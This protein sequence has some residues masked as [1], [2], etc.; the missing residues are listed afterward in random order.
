MLGNIGWWTFEAETHALINRFSGQRVR[1]EGALEVDAGSALHSRGHGPVRLRFCYEDA[2]VRYPVLVT[3]RYET[4][5]G[6]GFDHRDKVRMTLSWS[7]DH[8]GSGVEWRQASGSAAAVPPYGLWRRVD[9]ALF[10]VLACWPASE[11]T[12]PQPNRID[13]WGGWLNGIWS[14]RL[15]RVGMGREIEDT[16][17]GDGVQP[18]LEPLSSPPLSWHFVDA[19]RATAGVNLAGIETLSN[20]RR[21]LPRE[22]PLTGFE[23]AIPH[24]R[25]SDGKAVMYP[26][27][28]KSSLDKDGFYR[29]YGEFFYAD[30]DVFFRVDGRSW[31]PTRSNPPG[32][33]EFR[34]DELHD[35]GTRRDREATD[36]P[37]G[38]VCSRQ[39]YGWR[40]PNLQPLPRL[41]QRL[42]AALIDGWLAWSGSSLRL[43]DD[44]AQLAGL[45]SQGAPGPVPS[46][47]ESGI[48]LGAKSFVEIEYGYHGG[49]F[50]R[51][52]MTGYLQQDGWSEAGVPIH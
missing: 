37:A 22:A 20:G 29:P 15:R 39:I 32:A 43:P 10:D 40:G 36:L 48:D 23:N 12:G 3:A 52:N 21:F 44:P 18:Q 2:E 5:G 38:L 6:P 30:E 1:F 26:Y 27:R 17:V 19:R 47:A 25:R 33:W 28:V 51:N 13:S 11:A 41:A 45:L 14:P 31:L 8:L 4:Y 34:L 50:V 42:R 7:I 9:E 24:L 35:L 49:R 16:A 46:L